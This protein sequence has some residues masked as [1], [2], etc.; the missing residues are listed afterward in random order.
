MMRHN[1]Y[2]GVMLM[3]FLKMISIIIIFS[4]GVP[5]HMKEGGLKT[6]NLILFVMASPINFAEMEIIALSTS[7]IHRS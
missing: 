2:F 7:E 1:L 6:Q 4:A 5:N 3:I